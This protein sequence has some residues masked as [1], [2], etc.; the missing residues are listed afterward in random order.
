MKRLQEEAEKEEKR[1]EKE[2]SEM[3]K[4]LKRKQEEIERDQRRQEKE[5]AE[6]KKKRSL[7]KQAS[8][9]ERFLQ[10][11]KNDSVSQNAQ[12]ENVAIASDLSSSKEKMHEAVTL[13]MDSA[14]LQNEQIDIEEVRK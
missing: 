4:Q 3:R 10:K 6:Q 12:T 8:I 7:Q 14:L 11:N 9:M 13:A 2:D 1:R 5:E